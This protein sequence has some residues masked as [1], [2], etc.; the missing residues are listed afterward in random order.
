MLTLLRN[1]PQFMLAGTILSF[2]VFAYLV[3]F[4]WRRAHR[5][6]REA[7]RRHVRLLS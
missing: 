1:H 6:E 4:Q 3:G 7:W 2:A 5:S